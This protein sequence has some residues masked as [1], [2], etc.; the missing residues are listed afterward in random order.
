MKR[1][2]FI[3][4]DGTI[5]K[6]PAD[7]QVDS[8]SKLEFMPGVFTWLG[9][10]SKEL[11]FRLVMV[12]NQ[13]GLGT[14]SFPEETFWGPQNLIIKTL[15]GEGI[16]FDEI[17]I[18][19]SFD[20]E[21]KPTRKPGIAMLEHYLNG[22]FDI[23]NSWVIGDRATD[24]QLAKNLGCKSIFIGDN[25][26]I[27]ATANAKTWEDIYQIVKPQRTASISRKTNETEVSIDINLDGTGNSS[28]NSGLKFLDH[29]L[30]QLAKHSGIN[31]T[32]DCK[33][34]LEVDEHHTIEDIAITLGEALKVAIGD[35]KG[36]NRYG[37]CLPMDESNALV[38]L[39]FSGRPYL[40][41]NAEFKRERIGD[42]PTEMFMHFF[43]S[44]AYS[45]GLTLHI[46]A[47]GENEH[48]KI[49][50]I[51]KALAKSI[52]MAIQ[53]CGNQLPSTK[54]IL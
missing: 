50:A 15:E 5:I 4:R 9:K 40:V 2:L 28:I 53:Q 20:F 30:E 23:A 11:S 48:H 7:F 25:T 45:A 35:K 37:F 22:D 52:G 14:N 19:R 54:G 34:D 12:T 21:N 47:K 29:M 10:I 27:D 16:V 36:M 51:F 31:L 46:D 39:D 24:V 13:D 49:E 33:G 8:Y 43:H 3:D 17:L 41:W 32:I 42:V 1:V 18:D 44:L 6:E 26:N 38:T